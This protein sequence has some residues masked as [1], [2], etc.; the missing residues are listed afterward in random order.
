MGKY[1]IQTSGLGPQQ[2][3]INSGQ[4]LN[5]EISVDETLNR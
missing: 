2:L 5:H 3:N 4:T 1:D